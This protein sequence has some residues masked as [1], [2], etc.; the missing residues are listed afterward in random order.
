M[1]TSGTFALAYDIAEFVEESFERCG[2]PAEKLTARHAVSARRSVNLLFSEWA[3]LRIK[4]FAVD[5]QSQLLTDGD[6]TYTAATGTL[7]ILHAVVRRSGVDTPVRA[8]SR[9]AYH[10]IPSKTTEGSVTQL[11]FDRATGIYTLWNV[12]ENSTDTLYYWRLR[13]LQSVTA[14]QETPDVPF[15]WYEALTAGLAAKLALKWAADRFDKLDGLASRAFARADKS[16]VETADVEFD[17]GMG[18]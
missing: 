12:P 11:F 9:E 3:T 17:V 4:L 1:A 15:E 8:I 2:I 13:R 7:A 10:M 5:E 6:P 16:Q 18:S 14:A